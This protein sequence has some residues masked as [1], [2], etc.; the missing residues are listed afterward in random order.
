LPED[1]DLLLARTKALLR[2]FHL[3]AKKGLGQHFLIDPAMLEVSV[4]AA[5]ISPS[6]TIVE[7]GPGLG[8][9]TEKLG[10]SA[11]KVIAI[12]V[13]N[14]IVVHL[15]KLFSQQTNISILNED[16]L[17]IDI[18]DL[19]ENQ[20]PDSNLNYKVVAN[21]PYYIAAPIIRQFLEARITPRRMVVMVQKE[22]AES[23]AAIPGK[24]SLLGVSVQLY[25]K[26]HIV[27]Y[28]PAKSFYPSPKVD[29]AIVRIDVYEHPIV[30]VDIGGFFKVVK[31]GFSAPRKQLRNALAQGL[32][33]PPNDAADILNRAGISSQRRA[34]TLNLDEWAELHRTVNSNTFTGN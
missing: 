22:V 34:E 8:V 10:K 15:K 24:M 29:S 9:L 16:V 11:R 3:H 32:A 21:L 20:M 18:S 33:I 6:D 28:V 12:E 14:R 5:E 19:L 4:A 23:I 31:A 1:S 2:Q 26:P 25:G 7:V 13:D 17:K 27:E 30:E